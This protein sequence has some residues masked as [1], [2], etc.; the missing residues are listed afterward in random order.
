MHLTKNE[1]SICI[2]TV[3]ANH[4]LFYF[5]LS[6]FFSPINIIVITI[7]IMN[8]MCSQNIIIMSYWMTF[9]IPIVDFSFINDG[10]FMN[11][12]LVIAELVWF[13]SERAPFYLDERCRDNIP[14]DYKWRIIEGFYYLI[15]VFV[16]LL[17]ITRGIPARCLWI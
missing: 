14:I 10:N 7:T 6:T 15:F 17:K 3:K 8:S 2:W 16:D 5:S 11:L 4:N 12:I 1:N 9:C 13:N